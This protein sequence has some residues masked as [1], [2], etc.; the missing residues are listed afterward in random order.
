MFRTLNC[1]MK[2]ITEHMEDLQRSNALLQAN[3]GVLQMER[4]LAV[5]EAAKI[6]QLMSEETLNHLK[7]INS[8][9][10]E[11]LSYR[12]KLLCVERDRD[13]ISQSLTAAQ[14]EKADLECSLLSISND[15]KENGI[16]MKRQLD[17]EK[18]HCLELQQQMNQL[19][20][21]YMKK[22]NEMSQ[23]LIVMQRLQVE[24]NAKH[25]LDLTRLVAQGD[26]RIL[27][28]AQK[29]RT[30]I[31]QDLN[32]QNKKALETAIDKCRYRILLCV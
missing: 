12:E 4:T 6:R 17:I 14:M 24:T 32:E 25:Q 15:K 10:S 9:K 27:Q 30:E 19:Q 18:Q 7:L 16:E 5:D 8:L 22:I 21:D 2:Y 1:C 11:L 28:I 23:D 3:T 31:E 13:L 20:T 26:E 29:L